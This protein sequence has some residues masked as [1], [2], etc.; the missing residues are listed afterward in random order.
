MI[1]GFAGVGFMAY[2]WR[3]DSPLALTAARSNP[4]HEYR[5]RLRT[6]TK[7]MT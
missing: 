2:R 3:K 7:G 6:M 4:N 5:D 1:L